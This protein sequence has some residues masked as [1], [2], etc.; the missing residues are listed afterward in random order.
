MVRVLGRKP[1]CLG[2]KKKDP[3]LAGVFF[4]SRARRA[5]GQPTASK[6]LAATFLRTLAGSQ[7]RPFMAM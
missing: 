6:R 5:A 2:R 3:G 4:C 1:R 7:T